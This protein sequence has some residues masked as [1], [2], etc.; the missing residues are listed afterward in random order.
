MECMG[1]CL[2]NKYSEGYPN[3]RYYGGTE[4]IDKMELLTQKRALQAFNLDSNLWGVNVQALSG[5]PANFAIYTALLN[6]HDR[7]MGLSLTDGGHLTHGHMTA[8]RRISASS[9]YFESMSYG[10]LESGPIDYENLGKLSKR[11]LPK[12]IIAGASA[13]PMEINYKKFRE[14]CDNSEC[15]LLSDISHIAGLL[16]GNVLKNSPFDYSD[17]VMTT[18]HKTL[19]GPRGALIFYRKGQRGINKDG[20]S[21]MYDLEGKIN[22]AVF[23]T[24]QGGPHNNV[25]AGMC[26]CLKE[27]MSSDFKEYAQSVL[28]NAQTL[29]KSLKEYGYKLVCNGTET[30][31]IL[32]DLRPIKIN[33]TKISLVCDNVCISLNKNSVSGDKSVINPSGI[34]LGTAAITSRGMDVEDVEQVSK[35]LHQ[36]MLFY[37]SI[38]LSLEIQGDTKTL[39]EFKERMNQKVIISKMNELCSQVNEFAMKFDMPGFCIK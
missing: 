23:P 12:L 26:V 30:H 14:I 2:T 5:S 35:F 25:I 16:V 34:R 17:V 24:L 1:S 22:C 19:R 18:T 36:G 20:S 4:N 28:Q 31:L 39:V 21:I 8:N 13:Y 3:A 33:G 32:L 15:Y 11:F 37:S 10:T 7:L 38:Q 6:P 9:I 27:A 29:A